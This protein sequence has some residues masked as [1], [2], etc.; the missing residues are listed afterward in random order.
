M[1]AMTF[2]SGL[3]TRATG[4]PGPGD[5]PGD[6]LQTALALPPGVDGAFPGE[7]LALLHGLSPPMLQR[8]QEMVAGGM[9]LPQAARQLLSDSGLELGS[10]FDARLP[11]RLADLQADPLLG[12]RK[13]A[14]QVALSGLSTGQMAGLARALP[15]SVDGAVSAALMLPPSAQGQALS[16]PA[17]QLMTPQLAHS[18]LDMGVPQ[19]VGGRAWQGAIGERVLWMAQGEQQFAR[20]TLNPPHLGPLE[21]RVS[22]SQEQTSVLFLAHQATVREALDAAL[23]R[24]RELFDQQSLSLVHA[25]V[26]D[27]GTR[28]HDP[29]QS[30][31]GDASAGGTISGRGASDETD[32][33][34]LLSVPVVTAQGLVDLFV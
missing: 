28:Q 10:G 20:L 23:P 3:V 30:S 9:A 32:D 27:P 11:E 5:L 8:L 17:S 19:T 6:G 4:T 14:G 15:A 34:P 21:V 13:E 25:E 26:A 12:G 7:L 29:R 24:L 1:H 33:G 16:Q 2:L 18:L 22:I 31:P